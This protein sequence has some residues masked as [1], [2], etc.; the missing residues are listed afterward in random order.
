M[1]NSRHACRALVGKRLGRP[2]T[3]WKGNIKMNLQKI[4]LWEVN[5]IE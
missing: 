4:A 1:R 2:R 3:R 5:W